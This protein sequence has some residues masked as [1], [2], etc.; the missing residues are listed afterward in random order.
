MA[1]TLPQ[2]E[3]QSVQV[4][5]EIADW[6]IFGVKLPALPVAAGKPTAAAISRG[7]RA[8]GPNFRLTRKVQGKTVSKTFSSPAGLRKL[9]QTLV[10]VNERFARANRPIRGRPEL[11]CVLLQRRG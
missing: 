3:K 2:L 7:V 4:G 1:E 8:I 11:E 10:E 6:V 9:S 5:Q